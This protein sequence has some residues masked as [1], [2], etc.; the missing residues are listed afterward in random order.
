[1]SQAASM[2]LGARRV[3]VPQALDSTPTFGAAATLTRAFR[4]QIAESPIV[5]E[6]AAAE[7]DA[8]LELSIDSVRD[9]LELSAAPTVGVVAS[10]PKYSLIMSGTLRM[11]DSSGKVVWQSPTATVG[12]DYLTGVSSGGASGGEAVMTGTENNRR[13]AL[14]RVS[15]K[16][17][18][19]LYGLMVEGF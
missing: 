2:P 11:F 12:D 7:A 8:V 13:R 18:R 15:E 9:S 6:S 4:Q 16:L 3:F 5:H 19:E 1:M 17:A 10:V 14:E